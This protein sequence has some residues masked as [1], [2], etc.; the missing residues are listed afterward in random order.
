MTCV[1]DSITYKYNRL[2]V[3]TEPDTGTI[4]FDVDVERTKGDWRQHW[5]SKRRS[6]PVCVPELVNP[7]VPME[8]AFAQLM[9]REDCNS[10]QW[11]E[12]K[13]ESESESKSD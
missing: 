5:V 12:S 8:L 13:S 2:V 3:K 7:K 1:H 6:S 10:A 9:S 11:F 4:Y